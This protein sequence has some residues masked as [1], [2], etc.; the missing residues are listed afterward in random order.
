MAVATPARTGAV[1]GA[2]P[3]PKSK[4]TV[5]VGVPAP[6]GTAETRAVKVTLCPAVDGSG[7]EPSVI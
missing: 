3:S 7:E 5:P 1:T 4:V 2:V 6:G